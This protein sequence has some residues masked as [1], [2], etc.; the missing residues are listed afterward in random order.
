MQVPVR[1]MVYVRPVVEAYSARPSR[2]TAF[3]QSFSRTG[4]FAVMYSVG[5]TQAV[6]SAGSST[7]GA[8]GSVPATAP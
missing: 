8:A 3:R 5:S 4:W 7:S 6:S 1:L 2:T